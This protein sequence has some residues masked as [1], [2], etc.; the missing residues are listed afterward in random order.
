MYMTSLHFGVLTKEVKPPT[1]DP[2]SPIR[3]GCQYWVYH[4]KESKLVQP[5]GILEFLRAHFLH[6]FEAMALLGLLPDIL[7]IVAELLLV[8]GVSQGRWQKAFIIISLTWYS[9][10]C[11]I[12]IVRFPA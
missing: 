5:P 1:D 2:L 4:L 12:R 6:W 8:Q 9:A 10:S 11:K 7:Q 3:Y